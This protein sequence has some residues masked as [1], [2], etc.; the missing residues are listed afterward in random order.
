M[1]FWDLRLKYDV[2]IKAHGEHLSCNYIIKCSIICE[3]FARPL[4][5]TF[6]WR[7][8]WGVTKPMGRRGEWVSCISHCQ[9]PVA[10]ESH[11]EKG[12]SSLGFTSHTSGPYSLFAWAKYHSK[13]WSHHVL[14]MYDHASN[15][16]AVPYNWYKHV[17]RS[18]QVPE[19]EIL[20]GYS[21]TRCW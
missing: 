15:V 8:R 7:P 21:R 18:Y 16:C 11:T 3:E 6:R 9:N 12:T 5:K 20:K 10:R 19:A 4:L 1:L 2:L 14:C 17:I 13:H